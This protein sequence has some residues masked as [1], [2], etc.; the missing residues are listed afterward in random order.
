MAAFIVFLFYHSAKV[1]IDIKII[2]FIASYEKGCLRELIVHIFVDVF[3]ER[4]RKSGGQTIISKKKKKKQKG[5]KTQVYMSKRGEN[6]KQKKEIPNW[7]QRSSKGT[8]RKD[9]RN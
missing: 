7:S 3:V 6:S 4:R 9:K 2:L 5:L 1:Y 8:E